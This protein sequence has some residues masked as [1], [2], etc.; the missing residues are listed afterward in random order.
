[1]ASTTACWEKEFQSLVLI[2]GGRFFLVYKR[3]KGDDALLVPN[4][5]FE[6]EYFFCD[7]SDAHIRVSVRWA[8]IPRYAPACR[9]VNE[10]HCPTQLDNPNNISFSN[11]FFTA[12]G[13][14]LPNNVDI[15]QCGHVR[16]RP[17]VYG[18]IVSC[19]ES[20]EELG[21]VEEDVDADH[22]VSG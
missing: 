14:H 5:G 19:I 20:V 10:L 1:M 18:D 11:S 8:P 9:V 22:K 6:T 2:R 16:M 15:T 17:R 3:K 13:T 7:G 4:D 12:N 21:G